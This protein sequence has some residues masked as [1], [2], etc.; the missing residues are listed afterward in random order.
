MYR[1]GWCAIHDCALEISPDTS[2][3]GVKGRTDVVGACAGGAVL[4]GELCR[5]ILRLHASAERGNFM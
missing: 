4:G 2:F 1:C 5:A 3:S